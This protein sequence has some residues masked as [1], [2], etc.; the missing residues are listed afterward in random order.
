[1]ERKFLSFHLYHMYGFMVESLN[2]YMNQVIG[3]KMNIVC[4]SFI[5]TRIDG[6]VNGFSAF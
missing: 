4:W 3:L 1:M 5:A 6:N 2:I